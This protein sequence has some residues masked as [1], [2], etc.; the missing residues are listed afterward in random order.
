VRL[1][2]FGSDEQHFITQRGIDTFL[3][4]PKLSEPLRTAGLDYLCNVYE[5]G[6]LPG[7][8]RYRP[9]LRPIAEGKEAT[10]ASASILPESVNASPPLD[11]VP[12]L[13]QDAIMRTPTATAIRHQRKASR[14]AQSHVVNG[15]PVEAT[16]WSET[17]DGPEDFHSCG[18][19]SCEAGSTSERAA[20]CQIVAWCVA[21]VGFR[22][23]VHFKGYPARFNQWLSGK[24]LL[25]YHFEQ[26]TLDA[27]REGRAAWKKAPVKA[28]GARAQTASAAAAAAPAAAAAAAAAG[29]QG[30]RRSHKRTR[31]PATVVQ[32]SE[33]SGEEP[34]DDEEPEEA[35]SAGRGRDDS[36]DSDEEAGSS[37]SHGQ[38]QD[39]GEDDSNASSSSNE[40][41]D[42][43][44]PVTQQLEESDSSSS[45]GSSSASSSDDDRSESASASSLPCGATATRAC[46]GA[47]SEQ[48]KFVP[49]AM[50]GARRRTKGHLLLVHYKGFT[51]APE[52]MD[53]QTATVITKYF[54]E[55]GV[56][57]FLRQC[58]FPIE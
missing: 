25:P 27:F 14:P 5:T 54:G 24:M 21:G 49:C 56:K 34:T 19:S 42:V 16:D 15:A 29:G 31:S 1:P 40:M 18:V 58:G 50:M 11:L 26:S 46:A 2:I 7:C 35:A 55:P 53:W 3:S 39:A 52:D 37:S 6:P 23:R 32:D 45:A 13:T 12:L 38:E 33:Q 8:W 28:T 51:T 30:P 9:S 20:V 44:Q 43:G 57:A 36:T 48:G 4:R 22:Y 10:G 17:L 47:R 41:E